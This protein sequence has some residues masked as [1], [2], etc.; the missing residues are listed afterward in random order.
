MQ[1]W[2]KEAELYNVEHGQGESNVGEYHKWTVWGLSRIFG[3]AYI[4]IDFAHRPWS[5]RCISLI[6]DGVIAYYPIG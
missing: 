4:H 2:A 5:V 3:S 6:I 1:Y